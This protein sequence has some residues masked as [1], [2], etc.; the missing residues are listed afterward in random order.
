ME[1]LDTSAKL[2]SG[3]VLQVYVPSTTN[4][5]QVR[6]IKRTSAC[7]GDKAFFDYRE[8]QGRKRITIEAREEHTR[9]HRGR[10]G[11]SVGWRTHQPPVSKRQAREGRTVVY[12]AGTAL[13]PT[14]RTPRN[15][16]RRSRHQTRRA[17]AR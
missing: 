17:P 16:S 2:V 8:S 5:R 4:L 15:R 3:M 6:S 11:L 13:N 1:R 9:E 7:G 12:V 10:Y 14:G